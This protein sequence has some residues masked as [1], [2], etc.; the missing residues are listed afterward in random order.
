[1][2]INSTVNSI[3]QQ[4]SKTTEVQKSDSGKNFADLLYAHKKAEAS[5]IPVNTTNDA[6]QKMDT[7]K[8]VQDI[9][10]D[11]YFSRKP[12]PDTLSIMDIPLLLPT[13]HNVD[14]LAKYSEKKFK[15]LMDEYNIP[16]PPANIEFDS[17]GQ[18][19]LPADYPYADQL[20]Q[21]FEEKPKVED[22]LR[23]TAAIASHYVGIMEGQ[24]W[25]DEMSTART[26]ADAERITAKYSYL[27]DD[28]RPATK[29]VLSFTEDGNM[30]VG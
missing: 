16:A 2:L 13:Q 9:N 24:A 12:I 18:L 17:E 26:Q 30:L 10:L 8:G 27:F 6:A 21:A 28:N 22:A 19:V 7:N 5:R 14:T 3:Y 15:E 4:S 11:D 25:R 29:I 1:M 23:T 20:K